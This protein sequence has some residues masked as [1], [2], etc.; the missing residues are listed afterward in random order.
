M[1]LELEKSLELFFQTF[2][3]KL[4]L[5]L[6]LCFLGCSF[7]S[8]AERTFGTLQFVHPMT[9]KLLKLINE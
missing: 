4:S 7:T 1:N 5:I 9:Q 6:F 8:D 2:E 3:S